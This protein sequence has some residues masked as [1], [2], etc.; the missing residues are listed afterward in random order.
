MTN[1]CFVE[2]GVEAGTE[3]NTAKLIVE[4]ATPSEDGRRHNINPKR[5]VELLKQMQTA[6]VH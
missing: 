2:F 3:C 6:S 1:R 5:S 4:G